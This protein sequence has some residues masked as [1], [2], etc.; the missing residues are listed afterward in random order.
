MYRDVDVKYLYGLYIYGVY[1]YH[2]GSGGVQDTL[3]Q[4]LE[5]FALTQEPQYYSSDQWVSFDT[6]EIVGS[7]GWHEQE[8]LGYW[9]LQ[10]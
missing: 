4:R 6:E 5:S 8:G 9:A 3:Y 1:M 10:G 2:P 7:Y